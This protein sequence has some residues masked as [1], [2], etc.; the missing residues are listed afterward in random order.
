[1]FKKYFPLIIVFIVALFLRFYRLSDFRCLNWDEASFGYNAYSIL[2]T[3]KD[4]YGIKLPLQFK[5]VGDYKA[6][7][8]IYLSVPVIKILGL[9]EFS[10][11]FMPALLGS[12]CI[13]V[14]YFITKEL[15]NKERIS[16]LAALFLAISP[17]HIQFTK[18]GADV[19]VGTFFTLLG[20]YGFIKGTKG[21]KFGYFLSAIGF[22]GSIYSYFAERLFVPLIAVYL[23]VHFRKEVIKTKKNF[24]IAIFLGLLLLIP[25]VPSLISGG[26]EEKILKTTIFGYQRS[27]EYLN[28]IK[29]EDNSKLLYFLYHT[30]VFE[31]GWG[32]LNH[33]F[34]HFSPSFL[35]LEG[36]KEDPRQFVSNMGMLYLF[37]LPFI[38]IGIFYMVKKKEK[39]L[40]L[41]LAWLLLAPI[42]AAITKDLSSARRSFN[43]VY[44]LLIISSYG[45]DVVIDWV[46]RLSKRIRI[47]LT[48][49][50]LAVFVYL[51]SFYLVSY[52]ILTPP[53]GYPGPSGWFCGYK[54]LVSYIN[55]IK[56]DKTVVVDTSYQGPYIFFLFY[57]KY[58]PASYQKQARLVQES[59]NSLGEGAGYDNYI[60]KA[61]YWPEDRGSTNTIFAGPEERLPQKDLL[62]GEVEILNSINF[63]DGK[64]AFKVVKT[65]R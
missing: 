21:L 15:F 50:G 10:V 25:I 55:K 2:K 1:M 42:P 8:Y 63:P 62:K 61:I 39:H 16:L 28:R 33:Y 56:G 32:A 34:N 13:I 48:V 23:L 52:Y 9:N 4:E 19:G 47:T 29:E 53:K 7:L 31:N 41:I 12:L 65:I 14:F 57:E 18:A 22:V 11:R 58:D 20:I 26:H 5:S 51:V 40:R 46:S 49:L 27:K 38:L 6:P 64:E 3:G 45:L 44:P 24:I 60:F 30:S 59:V 17:W 54:G 35:F 36:V 43:M 37:D